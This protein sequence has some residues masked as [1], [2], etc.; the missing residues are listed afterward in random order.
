M[1][2]NKNGKL[3]IMQRLLVSNFTKIL[4]MVYD[5]HEKDYLWPNEK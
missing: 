1:A 2:K 5:T 4:I 3:N